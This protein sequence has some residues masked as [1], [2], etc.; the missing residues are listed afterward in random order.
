MSFP[1]SIRRFCIAMTNHR[2]R[3][4][5]ALLPWITLAAGSPA[6]A[7]PAI[8]V[9]FFATS[10]PQSECLAQARRTLEQ[11]GLT[12]SLSESTVKG[13]NGKSITVGWFAHHPEL[14]LSGV[15]ECNSRSGFGLF[16]VAGGNLSKTYDLYGTFYRLLAN[17]SSSGHE[18]S[19]GEPLTATSASLAARLAGMGAIPADRLGSR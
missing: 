12:A 10:L 18:S 9:N 1:F 16:G 2:Q 14:N 7:G 17:T 8:F 5:V 11:A 6:V 13:T 15:V 4:V 19:G 3:A